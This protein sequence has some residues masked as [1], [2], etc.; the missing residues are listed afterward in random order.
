ML[1]IKISLLRN[2]RS[3]FAFSHYSLHAFVS[4]EPTK[5]QLKYKE[6]LNLDCR[7]C[8]LCARR[9]RSLFVS[10]NESET[11]RNTSNTQ[12][13]LAPERS[14]S[15]EFDKSRLTGFISTGQAINYTHELNESR[16]LLA[17]EAIRS[18]S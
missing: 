12:R 3:A 18:P 16:H 17:F 13:K 14:L 7:D 9:T 15:R 11:P 1:S 8:G 6:A 10:P 5:C 4:R 2:G